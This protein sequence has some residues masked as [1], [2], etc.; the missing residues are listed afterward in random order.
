MVFLKVYYDIVIVLDFNLCVVFLMLDLLVVFDV[1]DYFIFVKCFKFF[2][3][4]GGDV[5]VWIEF[6]FINRY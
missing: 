1:I 2:Y 5:L 3:G 6:Y 4:I